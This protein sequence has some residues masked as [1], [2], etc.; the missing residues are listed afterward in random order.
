MNETNPS[1]IIRLLEQLPVIFYQS[2]M[3]YLNVR[4]I[5]N[6]CDKKNLPPVVKPGRVFQPTF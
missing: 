2:D 6:D 5:F 1:C 3:N 4:L